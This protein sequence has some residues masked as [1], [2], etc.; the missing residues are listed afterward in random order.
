MFMNQIAEKRLKKFDFGISRLK[1]YDQYNLKF[2][3]KFQET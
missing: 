3:I 1:L 2:N